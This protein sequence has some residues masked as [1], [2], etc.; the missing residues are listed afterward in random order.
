M[1]ERSAVDQAVS[2]YFE[3]INSNNTAII[4]LADDAVYTGPMVPGPITGE[5]AVRRHIAEI[6]PFVAR[7][8]QKLTIIEDDN[9]AVILEFEGVNGVVIEGV[10]FFRVR[11][12]K[13]C[14]N[15]TFFDT[16][17]LLEGTK[18]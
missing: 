17:P 13:I 15:Q 10:E 14:L 8:D 1:S 3:G 7:M 2:L 16:R 12:G 4:P 9:A 5:E 6:S 18:E 11:D